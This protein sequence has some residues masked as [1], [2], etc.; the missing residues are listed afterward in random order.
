MSE[1]FLRMGKIDDAA[2]NGGVAS[3]GYNETY[4]FDAS[5]NLKKMT[6]FAHDNDPKSTQMRIFYAVLHDAL[7]F[8]RTL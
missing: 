1:C 4:V 2:S 7:L 3:V 8:D 5:G 6:A